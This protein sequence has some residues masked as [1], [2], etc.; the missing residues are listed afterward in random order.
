[1]TLTDKDL[2]N[3]METLTYEEFK[4]MKKRWLQNLDFIWLIEGHLTEPDA[5]K[6]VRMT[7]ESINFKRINWQSVPVPRTVAFRDRTL[8][9]YTTKNG[10]PKNPN[11]YMRVLSQ[12]GPDDDS[13]WASLFVLMALIKEPSFK[14]LRT[15]E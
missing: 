15:I 3:A 11:A 8:Y 1:M 7:E 4:V 14:Q 6:L 5:L 12:V 10:D 13:T 2:L 9:T